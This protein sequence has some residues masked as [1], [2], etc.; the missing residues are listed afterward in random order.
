M[1]AALAKSSA[2]NPVMSAMLNRSPAMNGRSPRASST[3]AIASSA[4][5][6]FASAHSPICGVSI[7]FIAGWEWRKA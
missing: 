2:T 4:R 1:R 3:R 5:G 6:L 7:A